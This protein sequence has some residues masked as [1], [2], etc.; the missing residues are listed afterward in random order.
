MLM[1]APPRLLGWMLIVGLVVIATVN[2][3]WERREAERVHSAFT[4]RRPVTLPGATRRTTRGR[5]D[6]PN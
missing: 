1:L 4:S 5:W 3:W 2:W 6:P